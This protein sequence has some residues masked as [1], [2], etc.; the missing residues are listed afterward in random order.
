MWPC[1]TCFN[2]GPATP[3]NLQCVSSNATCFS[4]SWDDVPTRINFTATINEATPAEIDVNVD[5]MRQT[6]QVC[7]VV[8]GTLYNSS[9]FATNIAGDGEM[10]FV[11]DCSSGKDDFKVWNI[12]LLHV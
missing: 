8:T 2:Q 1:V 11:Q 10:A 9:V 5:S 4:L 12:L 7:Q 6:A 3:R